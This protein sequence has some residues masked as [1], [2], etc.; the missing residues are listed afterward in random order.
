MMK[1]P[2]GVP[3]SISRI[4]YISSSRGR[5]RVKGIDSMPGCFFFCELSKDGVPWRLVLSRIMLMESG[6]GD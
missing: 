5:F 4:R 1:Q 6:N 2:I 3:Q